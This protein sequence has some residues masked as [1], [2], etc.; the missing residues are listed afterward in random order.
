M[1][2]SRELKDSNEGGSGLQ[3]ITAKAK[4]HY[5]EIEIGCGFTSTT[6]IRE[7]RNEGEKK[8]GKYCI[9]TYLL[10]S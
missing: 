6:H 5:L 7:G 9:R 4:T 8:E 2:D 1:R 3:G 10:S